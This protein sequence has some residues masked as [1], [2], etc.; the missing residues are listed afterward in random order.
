MHQALLPASG[1][2]GLKS[3]FTHLSSPKRAASASEL[4]LSTPESIQII[5]SIAHAKMPNLY[6]N[7]PMGLKLV[8]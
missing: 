6:A 7:G 8:H 5:S 4:S 3:C 2:A 1:H